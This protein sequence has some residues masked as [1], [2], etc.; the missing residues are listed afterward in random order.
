MSVVPVAYTVWCGRMSQDSAGIAMAAI[1][2][3]EE[4]GVEV[5]VLHGAEDM[6]EGRIGGDVDVVADRPAINAMVRARKAFADA[7]VRPLT[8]WPYGKTG[9]A[10]ILFADKAAESSAIVD[11]LYDPAGKGPLGVRTGTLLDLS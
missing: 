9:S 5:A 7:G 6:K 4:G 3:L 1:R 10:A 2:S 8:A 11:M